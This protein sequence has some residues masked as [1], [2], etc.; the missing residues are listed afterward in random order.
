MADKLTKDS[1][2]VEVCSMIMNKPNEVTN[3]D[4]QK[5]SEVIKELASVPNPNNLWELGQLV[6][7]L[8]DE[9]LEKRL[10]QYIDLIAD[11]KRVPLGD[12]A[13]F[14]TQKGRVSALWQAK[15]STAQ[16][17]MVGTEYVTLETDEISAAPSIEIEALQNSQINFTSVVNEAAEAMETQFALRIQ[18]VIYAL[19]S[20]LPSPWYAS[21]NGVTSAIDP[22]IT[23]VS[24]IGAP[25][26]FADIAAAQKFINLAGFNNIV[27]DRIAEDFHK[28]GVIG[29]YRGAR[30][31]QLA[32]PLENETD[33][34]STI[35]DKGYIYV[36]P[37]SQSKDKRALKT[38]IEGEMQTF[39]TRYAQSRIL[40]I[41]MYKK[42]GVGIVSTRRSMG[43][44]E[45]TS[46]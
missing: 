19:W 32:N 7:F 27:A 29:N 41:A 43:L 23:G 25:L 31:L 1:K 18:T 15:G 13:M 30:I 16:R 8:V 17:S 40:E 9:K 2:I 38:V 22:I 21:A 37:S 46:L 26:I 42:I 36:V 10:N 33:M 5:A 20:T 4:Y 6:G 44:F 12:K 34:T 24:R 14:K 28:T 35:L 45:D 3:E 39:E 11:V